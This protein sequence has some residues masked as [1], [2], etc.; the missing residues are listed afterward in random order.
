MA[1]SRSDKN[2]V[3]SS[4]QRAQSALDKT[5]SWPTNV[6]AARDADK[7]ADIESIFTQIMITRPASD[8]TGTD[9]HRSATLSQ[10]LHL[11]AQNTSI[12]VDTGLMVRGDRGMKPSPLLHALDK[13]N[14][15][16]AALARQL[17][18]TSQNGA[19]Q[20]TVKANRLEHQRTRD[21]LDGL[22][23]NDLLARPH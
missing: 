18:L 7:Q 16:V 1:K 21:D 20:R 23:D 11:V 3:S 12:L 2:S 19:D 4:I 13:A 8:W 10:L 6:P 15:T 5:P 9:I 17:G 22:D 14:A